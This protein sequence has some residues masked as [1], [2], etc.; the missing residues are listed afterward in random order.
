VLKLIA[1]NTAAAALYAAIGVGLGAL[2]RNQVGAIIGALGWIFL[3]EPLLTL[4]PGFEDVITRWFPTGAANALAGTANSSDALD[5]VPAGLV[6][7]V[8]AAIFVAAGL[9][10]LRDRDVSA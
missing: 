8:Y 4:I 10:V 2:L 3:I 5:Q 9:F 1:G 7:A 6:L